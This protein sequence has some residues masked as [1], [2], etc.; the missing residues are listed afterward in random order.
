MYE[1]MRD[2]KRRWDRA[3]I[4]NQQ[5]WHLYERVVKL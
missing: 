4:F 1:H 2:G 5:A 3:G